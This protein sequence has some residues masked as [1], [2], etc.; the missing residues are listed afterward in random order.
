MP[1]EI[2]KVPDIG[3]IA[4]AE[5]LEVSIQIGDDVAVDDTL[6][7]LESDKASMEVP[8]P[9]AGR[10]TQLKVKPGEAVGQGH[11]I[12][13]IEVAAQTTA[14][15]STDAAS[16]DKA[17][18]A[19]PPTLPQPSIQTLYAPDLGSTE[20][21]QIIEINVKLGDQIHIDDTLITLES[22]KA[23]MEVPAT[24]AG[25][26]VSIAVN[27]GD[28]ITTGAAL[29]ELKV[30]ASQPQT[31]ATAA[32][33][34]ATQSAS[35]KPSQPSHTTTDA[36]LPGPVSEPAALGSTTIHAGPAV[37]KLARELGV[38]LHRV[39]GSGPKQRI[40]KD[41]LTR[42]VKKTLQQPA[43][44]AISSSGLPVIEDVD[45][46][47]FGSVEERPLKRIQILT[48]QNMQRNWLTIPHVTQ[49]DEAD[50]TE[51]EA[52]RQ[53]LKQEMEARGTKLSVLAFVVKACATALQQYPQFNVS[54]RADGRHF[55]QKHYINIG[56]AVDTPN[57]LIVPVIKQADQLSLWDLAQQII[58]LAQRG[59]KGKITADEMKG[60]CFTL[61]SL[62]GLGGT[63]FT[64]I[65]NAPE[66]AILG[67]SNNQIKPLWDGSQFQPRTILP[68]S[69]SYDHRAIN[70][71]DAARFTTF[72]KQ[73][74][75]DIRRLL[76]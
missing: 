52:F 59:R 73:A 67:L 56:I 30:A 15:E 55:V 9:V 1:I 8:S 49:F 44:M 10:I 41:D 24:A 60:G 35:P 4:S 71:A 48:A 40:V 69:L 32:A 46:S 22:D 20:S 75:S 57:G 37:R 43:P 28:S 21:A 26:V 62:G 25:E 11:E 7:V 74:L 72:I 31:P 17:D 12:A 42:W 3:D 63:A 13:Y 16:A 58:D 45:F 23:S 54:L 2:I 5:I 14:D 27:L 29:V 19:N 50:I 18:I 47:A 34:A 53:S 66:V 36:A 51:L 61:S 33:P 68:L 6:L 64:P 76:L 38:D 65:I 70:G 39:T